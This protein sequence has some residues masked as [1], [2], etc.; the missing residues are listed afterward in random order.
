MLH[1]VGETIDKHRAHYGV[2]TGRLVRIMRGIYVASEDDA[3][4]VL[5]DHALRIAA[6]LY[7]ST[8]LCGPSAELL[9]PTPDRRLFL[10]GRRNARTRL[11]ILEIVQIRAPDAPETETA[12]TTDPMGDLR[13][14]RST[15]RFRFLES[16]R[17][18]SDAGAA[19]PVDMQADIATRLVKS[20]GD[21]KT[22]IKDCRRLAEING[23]RK[24][25]GR[26][27]LFIT[28]PLRKAPPRGKALHVGW[29]GERIGMLSHD[30]SGWRWE[31]TTTGGAIPVRT[32]PPGCLPPFIE[33]LLPEG[34]LERV[35][36]PRSEQELISG[37]KRYMSNIVISEDADDLHT[38][39]AD[40][41]EGRLEAYSRMGAFTGG[42]AG[43][44][45]AFNETLEDRMAVLF[46][47]DRTPRLSGVQIKAPMNLSHTGV[48]RPAE[49]LAF[50]HILKPSP[51]AGFEDLPLVEAACLAAAR[52]C[53]FE[54][55]AHAMISMP[56]NLPNA[57]LVERFDIRQDRNDRR[58]IAIEDMASARGMAPSEKYEGSIEQV[59]RA[60]RNVSSD[61]E[62]DVAMLF[63]R[64]VFAWLI[65][66]GDCHLKNIAILLV[67]SDGAENFTSVRLAPVYDAV[68]TR[69]FPSL[70][71]DQLALSI[72]GKRHRLSSRDFVRAGVT[73]G[74]KAEAARDIVASLCGR[75]SIHLENLEPTANRVNRAFEIWKERIETT[76]D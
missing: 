12:Q 3:D 36:K 70:E 55:A 22:V 69:V 9:A 53:G 52:A 16:F 17:R 43:P 23:W 66:D 59:A 29:H 14:R 49:E 35:L 24:E 50:T 58:K 41:L 33:S 2:E 21:T 40:M 56:G 39:P 62:A 30:G 20:A 38:L 19:M 11:R 73:M 48:L 46:A 4:A 27:E 60:L 44:A 54:T 57:L 18:R 5:F 1:F 74:M 37:G 63:R 67:A 15:L 25:A 28:T 71:N 65:A 61:A 51:G 10:S 7:P 6:Y 26:V 34:W 13:V 68:T 76:A 31:R 47:S 32:G 72:A 42:Y 75:L 8:Y 64:A 45:P